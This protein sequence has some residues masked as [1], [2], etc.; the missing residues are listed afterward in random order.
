MT[1][2]VE[3]SSNFRLLKSI[4]VWSGFDSRHGHFF[5]IF[6]FFSSL[7][8]YYLPGYSQNTQRKYQVVDMYDILV[9]LPNERIAN[10][11][12]LTCTTLWSC[13]QTNALRIP[14]H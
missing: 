5:F 6:Q 8:F 10:T 11:N 9:M 14:N 12:T 4:H 7:L 2:Q 1:A 13:C 3:I